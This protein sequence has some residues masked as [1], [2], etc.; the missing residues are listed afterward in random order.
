M[1]QKL[2]ARMGRAT[3]CAHAHTDAEGCV[4]LPSASD[5]RGHLCRPATSCPQRG[6]TKDCACIFKLVPDPAC[7]RKLKTA[8][9]LEHMTSHE[10]GHE[11]R[12]GFCRLEYAAYPPPVWP[13]RRQTVTFTVHLNPSWGE[14]LK[15]RD[16][17]A[18]S[19]PALMLSVQGESLVGRL[20]NVTG[21]YC[22]LLVECCW[23]DRTPSE[24]RP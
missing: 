6:D 19:L 24:R 11:H 8:G 21:K 4:L 2:H 23:R 10:Q 5:K 9:L 13:D 1:P 14:C 15:H 20:V 12:Q 17:N 22:P 18:A 3:N 7:S 16:A